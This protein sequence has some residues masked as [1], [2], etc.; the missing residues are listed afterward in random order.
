MQF[1]IIIIIVI[2]RSSQCPLYEGIT[3]GQWQE[4]EIQIK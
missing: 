1:L 4:V 2:I 3:G